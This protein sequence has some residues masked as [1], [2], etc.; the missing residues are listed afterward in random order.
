MRHAD[1]KDAPTSV[2]WSPLQLPSPRT[3]QHHTDPVSDLSDTS[4]I[5]EAP[6]QE[7]HDKVINGV[8]II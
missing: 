6:C 8:N 2:Q 4:V 7:G 1:T 3:E 5:A